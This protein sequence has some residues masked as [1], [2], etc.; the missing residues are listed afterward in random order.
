MGG[1]TGDESNMENF[2]LEELFYLIGQTPGK[3]ILGD[4]KIREIILEKIS[5][6]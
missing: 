2:E 4:F 6:K 1:M 5:L 3:S